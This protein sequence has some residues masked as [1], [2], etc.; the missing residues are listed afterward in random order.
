MIAKRGDKKG[1][2]YLIA[3][4][5]IIIVL[6]GFFA[7]SNKLI[8]R[9]QETQT[10][11]LSKNLNVEGEQ[12]INH[13][14]F[15][16]KNLTYLLDSFTESYAKYINEDSDV[17]FTYLDKSREN[18]NIVAYQRVNTGGVSIDLGGGQSVEITTDSREIP[19]RVS[20][21][22]N[23]T[24]RTYNISV[25]G[26]YYYIILNEGENFFFVIQAPKPEKE[27]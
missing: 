15:N 24:Q 13:G 27:N 20:Q 2:F 19:F 12:V 22:I 21:P 8:S 5:I 1:Q 16:Q 14:V 10:Y 23:P 4:I 3:A 18:L 25:G 7:V 17:Y 11:E 26:N 9:P 6:V